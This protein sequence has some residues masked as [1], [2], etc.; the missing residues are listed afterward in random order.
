MSIRTVR[1]IEHRRVARPR[2]GSVDRL[3]LAMGVEAGQGGSAAELRVGVLGPL[4]IQ[5]GG[6]PVRLHSPRLRALLAR[7]CIQ[8]G[9]PVPRDELVDALWGPRPPRTC[10]ALVNS[11][12]ARLRETLEPSRIPGSPE[13]VIVLTAG[14]YRLDVNG[15][16][17]DLARFDDLIRRARSAR[18]QGELPIAQRLLEQALSCWRGPIL[19]DV[20]SRLAEHPA[21]V[22]AR[23][24][25]LEAAVIHADVSLDLD[26]PEQVLT[27]LPALLAEEPYTKGC[28]PA[29]CWP[30]PRQVTRRAAMTSYA[31]LR[32]RLVEELGVEPGPELATHRTC[33]C[34][35]GNRARLRRSAVTVHADACC[36]PI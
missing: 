12:I 10:R 1:N 3:F 32:A 19:A 33:G 18:A 30:R 13:P 4:E 6:I 7:L 35:A 27:I 20:D 9:Q 5:R 25:R 2:N 24:R 36:R 29:S 16:L 8:H 23:Q 15:E 21:A 11:Y 17:L 34:C 28:T 31:S 14:G 26:R 22:A